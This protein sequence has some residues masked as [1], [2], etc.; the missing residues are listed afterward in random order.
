MHFHSCIWS[1]IVYYLTIYC[2][3]IEAFLNICDNDARYLNAKRLDK[4]EKI[5]WPGGRFVTLSIFDPELDTIALTANAATF[6]TEKDEFYGLKH[7]SPTQL[8]LPPLDSSELDIQS[9]IFRYAGQDL[10]CLIS[11]RSFSFLN[12]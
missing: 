2:W 3:K 9:F 1:L 8:W 5:S 4:I 10:D 7:N 11:V 6:E 12:I